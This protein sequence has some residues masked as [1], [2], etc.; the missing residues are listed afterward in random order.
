MLI[1]SLESIQKRVASYSFGIFELF[2]DRGELRRHGQPVRIAPQP[3]R[4]LLLF[5][6]RAGHVVTR[7]ELRELNWGQ[8]VVVD[9]DLGLNRCIH[10]VR[11]ALLDDADAPRYLETIPR[12]GYRFIAPVR[13]VLAEDAPAVPKA[14]APTLNSVAVSPNPV[15][16][17][18]PRALESARDVDLPARQNSPAAIRKP[19]VWWAAMIGISAVLLFC[20][21]LYVRL[22]RHGIVRAAFT[23][24]P[25]ANESGMESNPSF[26][27]DGQQIAFSWNGEKQDNFDIYLKMVGSPALVQLTHDKDVDFSPAWSPDGRSIAFC[28]GKLQGSSAIWITSPLGGPE[29]KVTELRAPAAAGYR[30]LA[31]TPDN[32]ALIYPDRTTT[33]RTG[34][35]FVI[36]LQTGSRRQLIFPPPDSEDIYPAVAPDGHALAFTRDTGRGVSSLFLLPLQPDWSGA[37]AAVKLSWAGFEAVSSG[38]PNW[39]PDSKQLVF[40]SNRT[41]EHQLWM[42]RPEPGIQPELIASLGTDLSDSAISRTGALALVRSIFS[43]DIW[44]LDLAALR[45]G[46]PASPVRILASR[47]VQTTPSISPDGKKLAFESNRSGL[48]EI[49]TANIDGSEAA[50]LTNIQNPITGSPSWSH[51]GTRIAF[52][53][54]KTGLPNIYIVPAAGGTPVLLPGQTGRDVI[55]SWSSDDAWIFFTSDRSGTLQIWKMRPSG[56]I[57]EQVTHKGGFAAVASPDGMFLYYATS[58]VPGTSLK[59][60][61]LMNGTEVTVATNVLARGYFPAKDGV[62]YLTGNPY[63]NQSLKFYSSQSGKT[64]LIANFEQPIDK[65]VTLS[66]DGAQLFYGQINE[67]GSDLLLVEKFW[68]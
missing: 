40:I 24:T 28:R 41:G 31:W 3:L 58:R 51:D 29:R 47:R 2:P 8:E 23:P 46:L 35:L 21:A 1:H 13:V 43:V 52:D 48:A 14:D 25:L 18:Q 66:P 50:P 42:I 33:E 27:P 12:T 34:A 64:E 61:N 55:P 19:V 22:H 59:R 17:D 7:D 36:D 20:I 26:S 15:L 9:F 44:R 54:R 4:A 62:L 57:A 32:R 11:A 38:L 10:R 56:G 53:S 16:P 65:N 49:W 37:G 60:L 45:E 30:A 5:V 63:R 39:T 67:D 6:Q 68:H